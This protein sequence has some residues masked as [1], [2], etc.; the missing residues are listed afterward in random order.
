MPVV[1]VGTA[2]VLDEAGRISFL[3]A[4][5]PSPEIIDA[6]LIARRANDSER[7]E[8]D[9]SFDHIRWRGFLAIQ[10]NRESPQQCFFHEKVFI[11][12]GLNSTVQVS[13]DFW[14]DKLS[15]IGSLHS[16]RDDLASKSPT[17]MELC[18]P[19]LCVSLGLEPSQTDQQTEQYACAIVVAAS[20]LG[21]FDD[22]LGDDAAVGRRERGIFDLT[23]DD[24]FD[25]I[26]DFQRDFGH[27][28]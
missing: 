17:V 14:P 24:L 5:P 12:L 20:L 15:G 26:L 23:R 16:L 9:C 10:E 18:V 7:V 21:R 4:V 8:V 22:F 25:L 13:I 3:L 27:F 19:E 6:F 2:H 28:P 11:L 1:G